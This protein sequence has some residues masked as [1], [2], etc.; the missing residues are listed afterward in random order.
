[1]VDLAEIFTL[2]ISDTLQQR[3]PLAFRQPGRQD[4]AC[5]RRLIAVLFCLTDVFH[6]QTFLSKAG[7]VIVTPNR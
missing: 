6:E 4:L 5:A 2:P 7:T 3:E 1:M